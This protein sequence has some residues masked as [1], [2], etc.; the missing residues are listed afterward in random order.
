VAPPES[1][2]G[3]ADHGRTDGGGSGPSDPGPKDPGPN[4]PGA[5]FSCDGDSEAHAI[6]NALWTTFDESYALFDIRLPHTTWDA[7]GLA[8]CDALPTVTSDDALFDLLIGMGRELD[9][10]HVELYAPN[11][12]R[13][14]DAW[15]SVYP[16]EAVI[17]SVELDVETNHLDGDLSWAADDWFAWGKIGSVGYLSITSFDELS[18]AGDDEDA[19]IDAANAAMAAVMADIG[20]TDAMIVDLRANGGGWDTVALAT[21]AWFA[22][23]L[24]LAWSECVR[25]GPEHDDFGRWSD[26]HVEASDGDGYGG[27]VVLLTSGATLSAAETFA[28]AMRVRANVTVLG[29]R[30]AGYFSDMFEGVLPNGWVFQYSGERYRAADGNIYEGEGVPVDVAI[31]FDAPALAQGQDVMLEAALDLLEP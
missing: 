13:D 7:V 9:D 17:E 4:D 3:P 12:D 6:L 27:D 19:D 28:L 30:S 23:D 18:T 29:E 24:A 16:H 5:T 20:D 31:A 25:N 2:A 15:V 10:A 21:A 11:L 1:G 14:E 8:A 26:T 22:G